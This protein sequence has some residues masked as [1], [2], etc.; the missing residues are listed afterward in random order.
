MALTGKVGG[1]HQPVKDG[2]HLATCVS[3]FDLGTQAGGKFGAKRKVYIAFELADESREF[4]ADNGN[5]VQYRAKAFLECTL[6]MNEKSTLRKLLESWGGRKF[7]DEE[8]EAFDV[9][10][11]AGKPAQVLT[12]NNEK[13]YPEIKGV[14][15]VLKTQTVPPPLAKVQTYEMGNP[16]PEGLPDWLVRKI[17]SAPEFCDDES[18]DGDLSRYD[19]MDAGDGAPF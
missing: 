16:L 17:T 9:L 8:A 19:G 18:G 6:S 1:E 5:K 13:G 15:P 12:V 3:V 7:T 2:M 14:K 11:F 10:K 4:E